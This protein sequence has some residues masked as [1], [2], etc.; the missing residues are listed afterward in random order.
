MLSAYRVLDLSDERGQL[1]GQMLA[2][3]GAEVLLIEPPGGS[4]SRELG[5]FVEG[6]EGD[7][8]YSLWFWS[9]N[10]GKQSITVDLDTSEGQTELRHLAAGADMVIESDR[11]G[12]MA[13]RGLGPEDLAEVNPGLIYTSI[14]AFGCDG[15]KATWNAADLNIVGAGMQ[16]L[17]MGDADRPPVRIPLD[18]AFLHA[19][20]E[21]AA[22]TLVALYERNRSG[23][24]QHVD[25]SA[26][27]AILQATQSLALSHLYNSP[28]TTRTSGGISLGP[29]NIRLRSPAADGHVSTT[30]LFGE[31]IGPFGARLFE[32]IHEEGMCEDSDLEID[33]TNFVEGVMSG[34]IA[35]GEYDRIQQVAADFTATK[36]KA[37]L[38]EAAI[39][40]RL[41]IVPIADVADVANSDQYRQRDL[42][43]D[44][45]VPA[46]DRPVRFPGPFAKLSATPLE[47]ATPPPVIDGASSSIRATP[48]TPAPPL[49][50]APQEPE[51]GALAGLKILDFMWVMAGPAATRVM[52]DN[53]AQVVRVESAN[54]IET[55]RTIQ[56]F[57]NDEGGAE[58]SGL[59]QNMNAGKLSI[60]LDMTKPE[61][62]GVVEDLVRWADVVCESFS[63]RAMK[64]WGLGYEEL[65]AIKPDIIMASSC[66]FG[67]SGPLSRLAGYGSMGASLS[68]FYDVTGWPDRDPAGCF[69]AYTDYISPRYLSS[70]ILA[71]I[72]H[73]DRTGE[74]QHID[75]SQ[76]EAS[77]NF[78]TPS[79]LDYAVNG[80]LSPR[81][82]NRHASMA[83]HGVFPV[84]G[85]DRWITIV[86]EDDSQ[87]ERL[88]DLAGIDAAL[89]ELDLA[90]RQAREDEIEDLVAQWS[91]N[92]DGA[93]LE[94]AL[95]AAGIAA[96][97][98]QSSLDLVDD[99]QLVH[100]KHFISGQHDDHGT[101]WVEGSRFKLSRTPASIT[102]AGPTLGQHTF[103]VLLGILGYD[104]EKLGEIAAAGVLE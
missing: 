27:Q 53:G 15:P 72:D 50:L 102:K 16:L 65:K 98:A 28:E 78:L 82:G 64:A 61:S 100:R 62:R 37:E 69:G 19:S 71:A 31:A 39:E 70:A 52:A 63:P 30:I 83:P 41:L 48:R 18:Q 38:Q 80:H 40:R 51:G 92:Q 46:V 47:V 20:A 96:H 54:K 24:G 23:Q 66:L 17:M 7:P 45:E 88:V 12:L 74:G 22:G 87:W 56:P 42:W 11:P 86:C 84:E 34:R 29:F 76:A 4:R 32:W 90:A 60:T 73:R 101:M 58:N 97:R 6:H 33:W 3:L 13:E 25:V 93:E 49:A 59:Y 26:Q 75:L 21:A 67:Q 55:A 43:R 44:I 104:D 77:L 9:Y 57:L 95:Q 10:R 81:P 36:T 35:L 85:D 1:A 91:A 2:D 5:P 94:A 99:P 14:S 68:G 89:A 103:D 8:E 79:L